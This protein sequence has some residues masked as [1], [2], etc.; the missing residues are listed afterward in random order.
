M[1]TALT[2]PR[3]S[4]R[5]DNTQNF[6][7]PPPTACQHRTGCVVSVVMYILE[8]SGCCLDGTFAPAGCC[9]VVGKLT[10]IAIYSNSRVF[11]TARCSH[12]RPCWWASRWASTCWKGSCRSGSI[13]CCNVQSRPRFWKMRCRKRCMIKVRYVV[14]VT[15]SAK[16]R[17][18]FQGSQPA[19]WGYE[20]QNGANWNRLMVVPKPSLVS[21]RVSTVN[22][23][24]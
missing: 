5:K 9:V 2:Q 19:H 16:P 22:C 3:T 6:S 13:R 15:H 23:K 24:I 8:V 14:D 10:L 20:G 18:G 12:G 21:F 17:S 7:K 1:P 4:T 11:W